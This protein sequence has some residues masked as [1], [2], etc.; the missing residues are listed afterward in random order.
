[1]KSICV[2]KHQVVHTGIQNSHIGK[3]LSNEKPCQERF[4]CSYHTIIKEK[5]RRKKKTTRRLQ[6]QAVLIS[7]QLH[8]SE[9]ASALNKLQFALIGTLDGGSVWMSWGLNGWQGQTCSHTSAEG[10]G[11]GSCSC[12][13]LAAA[14]ALAAL[15]PSA[16]ECPQIWGKQVHAQPRW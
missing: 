3:E 16:K 15:L 11:A 5:R 13:C 8:S 12:L 6:E 14:P 2:M 7:Q 4:N 10:Q 9:A 1:M